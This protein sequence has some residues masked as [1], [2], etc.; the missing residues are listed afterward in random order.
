MLCKIIFRDHILHYRINFAYD[1]EICMDINSIRD[2]YGGVYGVQS[3]S[4]GIERLVHRDGDA[5]LN[6][7]RVM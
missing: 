6:R 2:V 1:S 5:N 7:Q 3:C 4:Y